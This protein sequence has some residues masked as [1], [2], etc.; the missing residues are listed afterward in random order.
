[1]AAAKAPDR[2]SRPQAGASGICLAP[3]IAPQAPPHESRATRSHHASHVIASQTG[4]KFS[5]DIPYAT[6]KVVGTK[7]GTRINS[8]CWWLGDWLLFGERHYDR[9]RDAVGATGLD[10][11]TLRNYAVI[12]RRFPLSRRRDNLSFQHHATVAAL[13]DE[14]QERWLDLAASNGW[15]LHALRTQIRDARAHRGRGLIVRFH[16][17]AAR[18]E[19]WSTAAAELGVSLQQWI[20]A[21]L[22][23]ATPRDP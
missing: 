5:P 19:R 12:A 10:Y 23:A 13:P 4:L 18:E 22:D 16:V 20:I 11:Q 21:T 3:S 7:L 2:S 15:S 9:Y 17:D 1:M 14:A 6:W 8:A